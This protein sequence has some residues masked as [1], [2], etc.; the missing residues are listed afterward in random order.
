M[1]TSSHFF[2]SDA[3][4]KARRL[5]LVVAVGLLIAAAW[6]AASSRMVSHAAPVI[7]ITPISWDV[8]GLDSQIAITS[9]LGPSS[10]PVGARVCNNGDTAATNLVATLV[11]S[12]ATPNT[13][14]NITGPV[15]H[16][17]SSLAPS[18]CVDFYYNVEV[19][20]NSTAFDTSRLYNIQVS[21]TGFSTISYTNPFLLYVERLNRYQNPSLLNKK[22]VGPSLVNLGSLYTYTLNIA[23]T[24]PISYSQ[25]VNGFSQSVSIFRLERVSASYSIPI[26]G[27]NNTVYVDACGWQRDPYAA[28]ARSCVGP[29]PDRFPDGVVGG[30][31][32][33]NFVVRVINTGNTVLNPLIYGFTSPITGTAR[34]QYEFN[35]GTTLGVQAVDP[36][37]LTPAATVTKSASV[38]Q[39]AINQNLTY[40][41]VVKNTGT[42]NLTNM[43]VSDSFPLAVDTVSA[44]SA[45]SSS[46]TGNVIGTVTLNT[47]S[48]SLTVTG[49][50]LTPGQTAT[51]TV[52]VRVNS[53][54]TVNATINNTATLT[55]TYNNVNCGGTSS[56]SFRVSG[57]VLPPTGGQEIEQEPAGLI[58]LPIVLAFLLGVGGVV[59][60]ILGVRANRRQ[61]EWAGWLSKTGA[62][63]M[64][65]ALVFGT[66]GWAVNRNPDLPAQVAVNQA[67]SPATPEVNLDWLRATEA[68]WENFPA[69]Q[70][71]ESLPDYPIPT[72]TLENAPA[73]GDPEP[74][75]SPVNRI[76]IPA[77][78][79][80]T[81]VKYVPYDGQSWMIAGLKQEV[82]WMGDTS[83]PGLGG[84]T[85][86]A[87][88]VTL[89]DGSNGPF[90][91]LP[92]LQ[93]GELVILYTEKNV[94]T[95]QVRENKLVEDEDL[96][97][98]KPSGKPE[99]T[100]ITCAEWDKELQTYLKR[101]IVYADQVGVNPVT[102][103]NR[104]N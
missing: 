69:G 59:V 75:T 25:L 19:T 86:F 27:T 71:P 21:G 2:R 58:A 79:V 41:I 3:W 61:S 5:T 38:D 53:S 76:R 17:L 55:C 36:N 91:T 22:L 4:V 102:N 16:T 1:K 98:L 90:R 83:W 28:N 24:T 57:S 11:W 13:L 94:Y 48:R 88:H 43:T 40:S 20:R 33:I 39:A 85:G 10:Y 42:A 95:Y 81:I 49:I 72:P 65:A 51:Y 50:S 64:I 96:T 87:G 103:Q 67:D 73:P 89:T 97:V 32:N 68:P 37:P 80:D 99:I 84:N 66:I 101:V 60:L 6:L 104:G 77:L 31:M 52:L 70:E 100:L 63:L 47:A 18:S 82:A 46:S 9:T 12:T 26:T 23:N 92:D 44:S 93:S 35:T 56:D 30:N 15:S 29:I 62:V 14:I 74:D 34:Y 8:I 54:A 78:G 45:L 7:T